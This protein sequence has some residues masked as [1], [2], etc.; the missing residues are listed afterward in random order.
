MLL[1]LAHRFGRH[2]A[3]TISL[4]DSCVFQHRV[5]RSCRSLHSFFMDKKSTLFL[6]SL[7][8]IGVIYVLWS[9]TDVDSEDDEGNHPSSSDTN[10]GIPEFIPTHEWQEVKKGQAVPPVC[11]AHSRSRYRACLS[12]LT[13]RQERITQS[14]WTKSP[15]RRIPCIIT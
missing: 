12:V 14:C 3:F 13:L 8:V 6:L 9:I 2:R 7:G 4:D 10:A 1:F 15:R 11:D 5:T